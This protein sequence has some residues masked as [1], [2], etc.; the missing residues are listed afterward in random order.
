MGH[1]PQA[2][3]FFLSQSHQGALIRGCI[4]GTSLSRLFEMSTSPH[5]NDWGFYTKMV[6]EFTA[7]WE[8][9]DV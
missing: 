8:T 5:R 9:E 3:T 1:P 6:E 7:M 2:G 4:L